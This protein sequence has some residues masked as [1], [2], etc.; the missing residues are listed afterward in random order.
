MSSFSFK[1]FSLNHDRSTM[2]IGTD[3]VLLAAFAEATSEMRLLDIGC[4]CG[5]VAFCVAQQ[6]AL[7]GVTPEVYGIEPDADSIAE[8]RANAAAYPLLPPGC[9]HFIQGRIQDFPAE[10]S[11]DLIVSN[12]P[13]FNDSLKPSDAGRLKSRHRDLQLP[14]EELL[15]SVCR[16]L[17]EDGRFVLI[18]PAAESKEFDKQAASHLCCMRRMFVQPTCRKPVYR[19]IQEYR[20]HDGNSACTESHLAIRDRQ[21]QYT[22]EYLQAT[23]PYLL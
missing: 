16:L 8:A 13:Y 7:Q 19:V 21:N 22:E 12:P 17:D 23:E 6:L 10:T 18:L 15:Q 14:F 20:K 1:R 3:A 11:F 5:V 9:F 4:G 2:K